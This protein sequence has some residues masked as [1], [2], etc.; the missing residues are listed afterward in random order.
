[1][2]NAWN[3]IFKTQGKVFLEPHADMPVLVQQLQNEGAK[4]VL[5][6]GSGSGR[7]VIY[8]AQQGFSVYGLDNAPEGLD[9]TRDWLAAAGLTAIL[10]QQNM[11]DPLPYAS[12]FFDA[13]ISVQVI[14]H[15]D[16]ATIK[17]IIGEIERVLKP[18][19]LLF[20]TVPVTN[21][22]QNVVELEPGTFLPLDGW[23]AGLAHHY[24]T[25]EE[26]RQVCVAFAILD[27]HGDG[28]NHTCLL[29]RKPG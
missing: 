23:E 11:T 25:P 1:M 14:H 3:T 10:C 12:E 18:G 20:V 27:I 21:H 26:L 17:H 28:V 16:I 22:H 13:V 15:A 24:F 29:A 7:H 9:M 8:L 4:T 2:T 19:G 6:L 5:D